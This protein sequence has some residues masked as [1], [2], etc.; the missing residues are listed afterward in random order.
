MAELTEQEKMLRGELFV[1]F[2]PELIAARNRCKYAYTRF[3]N[4]GEVPRRH[5]I[6]LWRDVVKDKTPLPPPVE[7]PVADD[8]LFKHEPWIEP[9]IK[10]DYGFNVFLGKDIFINSNCVFIDTMPITVG[11]RTLFGPNVSLFAGGHPVD[12]AVRNG[13]DGPEMGA[14]ITIQEDCWIGGNVTILPGVT[15]GK[16]S[17]VGAGSVVTKDVPAFHVVA[18]NP[19]RII[20]KIETAMRE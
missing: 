20:R 8:E 2:T 5:L 11:D 19:A 6:E 10:V 3:N 1:S 15:I 14:P 18:G 13:M 17:T 4:A 16:G 12:P 7:D 9:P